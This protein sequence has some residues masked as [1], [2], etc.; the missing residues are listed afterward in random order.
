MT[1]MQ[2]LPPAWTAT[3]S[4][5]VPNTVQ[6]S[7]AVI[8]DSGVD[9]IGVIAW[10][11]T[12]SDY[13]MYQGIDLTSMQV[14]WSVAANGGLQVAGSGIL[15][16]V[17]D[18][19]TETID[20]RTGIVNRLTT[21]PNEW[22]QFA[23]DNMIVTRDS[24]TGMMCGRQVMTP[25]SCL[26]QTNADLVPGTVQFDGNKW[27]NTT[28]GV[29]ELSTGLPAPFGQDATIDDATG[30]SIYYT[31]PDA[32]H[33]MRVTTS[34]TGSTFQPWSTSDD[35][36][37]GPS[38]TV[39][40]HVSGFTPDFPFLL[41]DD[42]LGAPGPLN[43]Y[44]W[45]TGDQLWS[46]DLPLYGVESLIWHGDVLYVTDEWDS[47]MDS[48]TDTHQVVLNTNSGQS[49]WSAA[50]YHL[51]GSSG[52]TTYLTNQG[53]LYAFDSSFTPLWKLPL[54]T[55]DTRVYQVGDQVVALSPA[56]DQLSRLLY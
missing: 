17:D 39:T 43:A 10:P 56:T 11:I 13:S 52:N 55:D 23:G 46:V 41:V 9:N 49:I 4:L 12:N 53:R 29:I 40:G 37:L 19:V 48:P 38:V 21:A 5:T 22:P 30:D 32:A 35:R 26:W 27:I 50:D 34:S 1:Q 2:L 44:S 47:P 16:T 36:A 51:V 14:L 54:P 42:G 15:L 18:T 3:I 25:N 24:D 33:I 31:G 7:R 20:A 45:T 8:L 6:G 28:S